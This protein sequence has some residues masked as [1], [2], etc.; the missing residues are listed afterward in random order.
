MEALEGAQ[1]FAWSVSELRALRSSGPGQGCRNCSH[2]RF[3]F[4]TLKEWAG[5]KQA[6][7]GG[8]EINPGVMK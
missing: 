6:E 7:E 2:T 5:T 4:Q 1:G 3:E 8:S